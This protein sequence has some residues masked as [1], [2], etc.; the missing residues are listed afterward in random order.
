MKRVLAAVF[1]TGSLLLAQEFRVGSQVTDFPLKT[2]SGSPTQ[3]STLKGDVTVVMFI[4]AQCP[5]S[6]SYNERMNALFHDYSPKGVHFVAINSNMTESVDWVTSHAREHHFDFPV[7]KDWNNVVADRFGATATPETY[8]VDKAGTVRYHGS[9][10]DSQEVSR[11][12]KQRL[13]L[14]LDAV[15]AGKEPPQTETKAFGCTIK[16]VRST[17]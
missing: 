13:R 4:S 16:R 14:A 5:V 3:F 10:D 9:I 8:V 12:K 17:Q 15:L 7:Y 6:N 1:L 11:V 2:L